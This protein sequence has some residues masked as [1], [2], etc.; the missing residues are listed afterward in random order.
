[1][2]FRLWLNPRP[3]VLGTAVT[4]LTL[5]LG[6][7]IAK[8]LLEPRLAGGGGSQPELWVCVCLCVCVC[9]DGWART[10]SGLVV[11]WVKVRQRKIKGK[12]M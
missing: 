5:R 3:L 10:P 4:T 1:M 8:R 2:R 7:A 12:R 11:T 9:Y 6:L